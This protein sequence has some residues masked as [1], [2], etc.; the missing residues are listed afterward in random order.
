M[1]PDTAAKQV[2][3][4]HK[5][6]LEI[7][8]GPLGKYSEMTSFASRNAELALRLATVMAF[9]DKMPGI[10][11]DYMARA[12]KLA[13]YSL[14]EWHRFIETNSKTTIIKDADFLMDWML[15]NGNKRKERWLSFD[16]TMAGK[17]WPEAYRPAKTRDQILKVLVEHNQLLT[18]DGKV[19]SINPLAESAEPAEHQQQCGS[20]SDDGLRRPA[21]KLKVKFEA[22]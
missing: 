4:D 14:D 16:K 13:R 7:E 15:K 10:N 12:C 5:N 11:A 19:F 1:E 17:A 20:A 22:V 6:E 8:Q 18:E 3:I 2:W 9:F 21:E